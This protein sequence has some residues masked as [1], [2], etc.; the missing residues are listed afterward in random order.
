[1]IEQGTAGHMQAEPTTDP[2]VNVILTRLDELDRKPLP[3][4]VE[5]F[6]SVHTS[7][8]DLLARSED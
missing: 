7:L 4:H 6:D 3:A 2:E 8:Q 1:M 5:V